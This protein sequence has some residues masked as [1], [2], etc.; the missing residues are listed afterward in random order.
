MEMD[1][2]RE[3]IKDKIDHI[4]KQIDHI[5]NQVTKTNGRVTKLELWKAGLT[6]SVVVILFLIGAC[7]VP[8]I[9]RVLAQSIIGG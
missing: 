2:F 5:D 1:Q 6:G 7:L 4:D 8:I 9:V 3:Y